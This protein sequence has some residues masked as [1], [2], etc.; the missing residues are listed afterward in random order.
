MSCRLCVSIGVGFGDEDHGYGSLG[1][2]VRGEHHY[3]QLLD[4]I[5]IYH[6]F[7]RK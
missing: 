2:P 1:G 5:S 6:L 7:D 4:C 3:Q